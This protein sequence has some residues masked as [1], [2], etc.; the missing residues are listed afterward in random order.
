MSL[1]RSL[2]ILKTTSCPAINENMADLWSSLNPALSSS[3]LDVLNDLSFN[4]MTPVQVRTWWM[5]YLYTNFE[6]LRIFRGVFQEFTDTRLTRAWHVWL[7][8]QQ[9]TLRMKFFVP[10]GDD[11]PFTSVQQG[12]SCRS[13]KWIYNNIVML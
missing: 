6:A 8:C 9:K 12:C 7:F 11:N 10:L 13:C 1:M 3:T 2:M 5:F 4:S